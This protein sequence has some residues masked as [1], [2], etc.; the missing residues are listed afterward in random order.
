MKICQVLS[1]YLRDDAR[2]FYR[3]SLSLKKISEIKILLDDGKPEEIISDIEIKSV[4]YIYKSKNRLVDYYFKKKL[5]INKIKEIDADIYILHSPELLLLVNDLKKLGKKIIYDAHEDMKSHIKEKEWLPKL[6]RNPLSL[7]VNTYMMRKFSQIDGIITP[8]THL[9]YRFLEYGLNVEL[10]ENFPKVT[11]NSEINTNKKYMCYTGTVYQ[12]SY[13]NEI[14][15]AINNS[16]IIEEYQIAGYIPDNIEKIL[17][18]SKKYKFVGRLNKVQLSNFYKNALAGFVLYDYKRN[19]GYKAGSYGSNKLFEYLEAGVAVICTDYYLW[20]YIIDK[21][22]CGYY[23][24]VSDINTIQSQL[25]IILK[26]KNALIE[27]GK[28]GKRAI[29]QEFNWNISEKKLLNFIAE[30]K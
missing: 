15:N 21:Y 17:K 20:K 29:V 18:T 3:Q 24:D 7:I 25:E 4:P 12:Y 6:V 19:L 14:I 13:Q 2:I 9:L 27:K 30:I 8:H 26:D 11:S 10:I 22:D 1:G 23:I 28:N 5:Y 16:D